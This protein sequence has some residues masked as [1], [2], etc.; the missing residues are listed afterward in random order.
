MMVDEY[1]G[2]CII[3]STTITYENIYVFNIIYRIVKYGHNITTGK[4][5]KHLEQY[6]LY[7]K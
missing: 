2:M 1:V 6:I 4:T 3:F 5:E 7:N